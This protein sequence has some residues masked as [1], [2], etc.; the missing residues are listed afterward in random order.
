MKLAGRRKRGRP[1]QRFTDVV[2]GVTEED[3]KNRVKVE[4]HDLL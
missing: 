2:R 3:A 4:V 1:Q